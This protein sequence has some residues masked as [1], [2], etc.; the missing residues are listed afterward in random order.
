MTTKYYPEKMKEWRI[1]H[2]TY[3]SEYMKTYVRKT[4]KKYNPEKEHEYYLKNKERKAINSK[5]WI[6]NNPER[7][8]LLLKSR[9][10]SLRAAGKFPKNEWIKK[11]VELH[12]K[13]QI[14]FKSEPE[15]KI[16]IDHIIPLKRGGTNDIDNLQPLCLSCNSRKRD[17]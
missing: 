12:Y 14:C 9:R 8:K 11:L 3:S 10:H 5:N 7:H 15:V 13:C 16:T 6:K 1:A 17:K 2:P 4:P